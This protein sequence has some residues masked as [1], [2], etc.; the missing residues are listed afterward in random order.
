M[1]G[2]RIEPDNNDIVVWRLDEASAPF[3]NSSTSTNAIS[4]ATSNLTTLS[5]TVLT[6]HFINKI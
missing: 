2:I 5:G 1:A 3:V 6:Q 4:T